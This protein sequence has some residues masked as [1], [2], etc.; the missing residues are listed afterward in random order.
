MALCGVEFNDDGI[1]W[2]V[3]NV[4]W[5]ASENEP[6]VWYYDVNSAQR[7]GVDVETLK[8]HTRQY[9]SL[10]VGIVPDCLERSSVWEV[11]EWIL[12]YKSTRNG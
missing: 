5:S 8:S 2:K 11:R 1:L 4:T 7:S 12:A 9:E 3:V 6:V 10:K